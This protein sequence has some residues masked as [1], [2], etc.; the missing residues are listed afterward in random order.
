MLWLS[1]RC[2]L[3]WLFSLTENTTEEETQFFFLDPFMSGVCCHLS[4][5]GFG[6]KTP[7]IKGNQ[8]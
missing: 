8:L 4:F 3:K 1:L 2:I 6:R 5:L 7:T